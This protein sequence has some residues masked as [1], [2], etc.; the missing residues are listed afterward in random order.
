MSGY[1]NL[2]P[3]VSQEP[4][5]ASAGG[6]FSGEDKAFESLV[7]QTD[8]PVIDWEM[9]L[10]SEISSD[11][12]LRKSKQ[13]ATT[14]CFTGGDF[15]ESPDPSVSFTFLSATAG[16]ESKLQIVGCDAIVNGWDVHVE[17]TG[18]TT[19]D[20]N[21]VEL[22]APPA[23]GTRVDLVV[24]E[25][26]RALI[27]AIPSVVNK[28]AT[29][30]ILRHGNV[31]APDGVNLPD[32]LID[33]NYGVESNARVQ[34][35]Y[36]LRVVDN[37]NVSTYPDGLDD[38]TVLAHT[39]SDFGGAG[40][41]GTVTAFAFS[42]T[43]HDKGLWRA[44]TGD[45]AG[46]TS[47]GTVDG[48][49]YAVPVCA[50][51]RRNSTAF[52]RASN[53]NGGSLIASGTSDR[54]D[55]LF[56][57]QIVVS[58]VRDLRKGAAQSFDE[59]LDKTV[60]MLMDNSLS[61][62]SETSDLG[63]AGTS[64][65]YKDD[66]SSTG[67][68]GNADGVRRYFSDRSITETIVGTVEV[69][70]LP[71]TTAVVTLSQLLTP[72]SAS[73]YDLPLNAPT[74]TN[75]YAVLSARITDPLTG[76]SMSTDLFDV[77]EAYYITSLVYGTDVSGIDQIT[78]TLNTSVS[79]CILWFELAIEYQPGNGSSRNLLESHE[80]WAPDTGLAAW[81]D[82]SSWTATSD[83]DRSLLPTDHWWV[84]PGHREVALRVLYPDS[85]DLMTHEE[86][87]VYIPER[88]N[89]DAVTIDDGV[90][91]P[92]VTTSYTFNTAMTLIE[93]SG[94]TPIAAG[95]L[96]NV[97]FTAWAP[98]PELVAAPAD[99]VN[100]FYQSRAIQSISPP[101]GTQTLNLYPRAYA[102][103]V[104]VICSGSGSPDDSFPFYSPSS[105]LP[106]GLLPAASYPESHL[107]SPADMG[108]I[109]FNINT[110]F[111]V[112]P[113]M[114]PYM[115]NPS[116]VTLFRDAPD[117]T[118]DAEG[119]F[120]WPK[121]DSGS[122]PKY[123]PVLFSQPL[124]G[125]RRHQVSYPVLM[126]LREDFNSIG[127]KGTVVL[128]VFTSWSEFDPQNKIELTSI[129]GAS[130]AGIFRVRGNYMNSRRSD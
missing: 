107:D 78:V 88:L 123:S 73:T 91:P 54:P 4:Q 85:F 66:I 99:S 45:S 18:T 90:N 116:E 34:I 102:K 74:G 41:D 22:S 115:P 11:Y 75:I 19:A 5:S 27:K 77:T 112:L 10:R 13:K 47:L 79:D 110:G 113:A 43:S 103:G 32:D 30:L 7:V 89:G 46:A 93:L 2:G 111:F 81:I 97:S 31:K 106:T 124:S 129:E 57:D 42:A 105:Q 48:Y 82:S 108:V 61:T 35:Q 63:T 118:E 40:A 36:R 104:T 72:F 3:D 33:P 51:H 128:V 52:N 127:K 84:D 114:I 95:S 109:G 38:P 121:S 62:S 64:F 23:A 59:I 24:L 12:G 15:L 20:L 71:V 119:R 100:L 17:F 6:E 130:A 98:L 9:N 101:A 37:V 58:D 14:S 50:V 80:L 125:P 16:N 117:V 8:A 76:Q 60:H 68:F 39:V 83:A 1:R 120:F 92:Y 86:D 49:M 69:G 28:S 94:A 55:D 26:W 53:L 122:T 70:G 65:L 96:V 21:E 67:S 44:G 87:M 29:G 126:E 25:V 56:A